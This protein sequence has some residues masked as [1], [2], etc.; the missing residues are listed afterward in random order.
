MEK[1]LQH[2]SEEER[3][4]ILEDLDQKERENMRLRRQK[5]SLEHFEP[6]TLIGRGAFGEVS[7]APVEH[8]ILLL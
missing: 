5:F 8:V 4:A 3:Q 6:L 1:Q 7:I 2:L